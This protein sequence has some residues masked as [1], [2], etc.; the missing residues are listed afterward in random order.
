MSITR[1]GLKKKRSLP[2]APLYRD[3]HSEA[4]K[5]TKNSL[6]NIDNMQKSK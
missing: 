5:R 2:L 6:A 4:H 3:T 1:N